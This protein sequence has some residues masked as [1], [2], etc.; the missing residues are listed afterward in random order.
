VLLTVINSSGVERLERRLGYEFK[1]RDLLLRS[2]TNRSFGAHNNERLEFLG[3]SVLG[4]I[5]GEYLFRQYSNVSE[6]QLTRMR[7]I[8][9]KGE[10]LADIAREMD[11]GDFLVLGEGERKSGGQNRESILA[12]AVESLIAV[13]YLESG[14]DVCRDVVLGWLDSRL[15]NLAA[16]RTNKDPKTKLQELMQSKGA[17]LPEYTIVTVTGASHNQQIT[18]ACHVSEPNLTTTATARNRK[19]AEKKSASL[20]LEQLQS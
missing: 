20:A 11:L 1:D 16:D 4:L 17:P 10:T 13:I 19:L 18:V 12:D 6:G 15:T 2:L 7:S 8:L 3:D 9:V 14:L 5:V